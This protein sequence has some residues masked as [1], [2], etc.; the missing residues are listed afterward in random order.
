MKHKKDETILDQFEKPIEITKTGIKMP[1]AV[2]ILLAFAA[3][4]FLAF[5]VSDFTLLGCH[6][7]SLP[8]PWGKR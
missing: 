7:P 6:K 4:T 5:W 1:A 2:F 3:I 8:L